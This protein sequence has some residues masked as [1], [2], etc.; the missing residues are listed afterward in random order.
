MKLKKAHLPSLLVMTL[1]IYLLLSGGYIH[2]KAQVAQWLIAS[3]W[4]TSNVEKSKPWPWAD[5]WPVARL[6]MPQHQIDH[7]VL[8]GVSGE[9]LAFGP[10]Y[11]FSSA[12]PAKKGNTRVAAH[13]DTHFSFLEH[14]KIGEKVSVTNTQGEIK[15]YTIQDM[16]IVDKTDVEWINSNN[17]PY[18]LTL[19]TCYPFNAII[20]GGR[21]RYVVRAVA[22]ELLLTS[23]S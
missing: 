23:L 16:R 8:A 1:S 19:V 6:T 4:Q 3:A 21:L 2:A 7:Y 17:S 14:V 12:K 13:R 20:P 18:Q 22:P 11:V 5:T 9:S 15:E 10:G